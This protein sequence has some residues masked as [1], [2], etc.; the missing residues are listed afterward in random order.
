MANIVVL[1]SSGHARVVLDILARTEEH[2]VI[3]IIDPNRA[4]GAMSFGHKVLGGDEKLDELTDEYRLEGCIVAVGDNWKR[5]QIVE[6]ISK[7]VSAL[8]FMV[9]IHPSAEVGADV[10]IGPG[11]VLMPGAVVNAG[12]SI[13][14]H[15]IIN[16]SA[17]IDHDCLIGDYASIAPNS[18]L[19][20]NVKVGDHSAISL[21][22]NVIHGIKVGA[23][24]VVGAGA[25]VVEDLPANV[26]AYGVPA[27]IVRERARD[28][29]YL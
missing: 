25:V 7:Q 23:Y 6:R 8:S 27:R 24:T 18:T 10:E 12:S 19:G 11:S 16:T 2:N 20:G 9:A 28:E 22:A 3:G 26:V 21:G 15:C 14:D 4:P 5:G 1:G 13:G 17:S 29:P